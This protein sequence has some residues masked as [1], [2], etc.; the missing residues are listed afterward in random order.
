MRWPSVIHSRKT[1]YLGLDIT[2]TSIKLLAL[3]YK[4]EQYWIQAFGHCALDAG[5]MQGHFVHDISGLAQAIQQLLIDL[6]LWSKTQSDL[7]IVIA[8]PD[9]CTI[10]KII[11]VSE[12]LSDEDIE[13]LVHLELDK[14]SP[15]AA[16][17]LCFDFKR[18]QVSSNP[19][20]NLKEILIVAARIQ[21]VQDRVSALQAIGLRTKVVDIESFAIRRVFP[22]I[23]IETPGVALLLDIT[24]PFLKIYFFK[25]QHLIFL[26]EEECDGL[27][28][29][30]MTTEDPS[31]ALYLESMLLRI[32]RACHFFYAAHPQYEDIT[33]IFLSG[34][35]AQW[36]NLKA[37]LEQRLSKPIQ[38][39]NPFLQMNALSE[40]NLHDL[41]REA[42]LYLTAC[43]LA[44]RVC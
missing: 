40:S 11:T 38:I 35:G 41:H 20:S 22:F 34:I 8:L 4:N 1:I 9:A 25:N 24:M 33:Q 30:L 13:E 10:N 15:G 31:L 39:A 28:P 19:G 44:K 17:D 43:G 18:L 21:H 12:R 42:A 16:Y 26:R 37:F 36:G 2:T 7:E 23:A 3:Y 29:T 6:E 27:F 5:V 14:W 32:K